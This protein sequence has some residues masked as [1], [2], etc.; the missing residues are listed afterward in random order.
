MAVERRKRMRTGDRNA[1]ERDKCRESLSSHRVDSPR[2]APSYV[3]Y[4]HLDSTW[5]YWYN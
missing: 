2:F 3:D 1:Q 4:V 5:N